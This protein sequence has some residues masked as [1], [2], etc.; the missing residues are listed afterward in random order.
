MFKNQS[1]RIGMEVLNCPFE[2]GLFS[3]TCRIIYKIVDLKAVVFQ[4]QLYNVPVAC[5]NGIG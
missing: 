3:I 5:Q 2:K 1:C 4:D